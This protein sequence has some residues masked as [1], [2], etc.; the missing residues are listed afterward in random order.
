MSAPRICVVGSSIIDLVAYAPAVPRMGETRPG[1]RFRQGFGGKGANQA[2]MAA[3][4]G[5]QVAIVSKV[6]VDA[7]GTDYIANFRALGIDTTNVTVTDQASTGIAAIWVEE[8]SGNNAIIVV[9]GANALQRPADVE[10]ARSAL[11]AADVVVCQWEIPIDT[12]LAA[13]RVAR[14]AGVTT[15]F[16][17]A[18]AQ[19]PL[20]DELYRLTDVLC[21]NE[22]E[23][24]VLT[25]M[26]TATLEQVGDAA[27][28]LLGR[29]AARVI[30]T[31]GER[32]ALLVT[33]DHVAHA[34]T[35]RVRAVDTTGAGD[36]FVGS[37]AFFAARG[38]GWEDAMHRAARI[39][40]RTVLLPGTQASFPTAHEIPE[41]LT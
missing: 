13:L 9:L 19:G 28:A 2:V 14:A 5:A 10:A 4:L 22:T 34:P 30:C 37:L 12:V 20:P 40:A 32:G 1:S 15:V 18:P 29:G 7:F 11:E 16:N 25:G 38:Q 26:P 21:P 24:E 36:A 6:G 35:E 3:R 8:A 33:P 39:A 41:L 31:L 23:T 27:R 17:P